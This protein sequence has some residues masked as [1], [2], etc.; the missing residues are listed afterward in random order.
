M[1]EALEP[2]VHLGRHLPVV[3][4]ETVEGVL[5]GM[6]PLGDMEIL[7]GDKL[8]D[9]E[10]VVELHHTDLLPGIGDPRLLVGFRAALA[11][12]DKML[13]VPLV[14]T[15]LVT[16]VDGKLDCLDGNEFLLP[17]RFGDL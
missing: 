11:G 5:P 15:R 2:P 12:R 3:V 8:C 9:R 14:E 13:P 4:V 6:A 7:V 1:A 16:A 17:E 10:A